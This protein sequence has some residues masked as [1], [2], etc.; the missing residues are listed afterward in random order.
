MVEELHGNVQ[1]L[2][3]YVRQM[4]RFETLFE[5]YETPESKF[6]HAMDNFQP[7]LLNHSNDGGDWREHGVRRSQ[8]MGRQNGTRPGSEELWQ[9]TK[10]LIDAH[11]A[12]GDIKDE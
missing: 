8:V 4:E 11:V 2:R 9:Y 12:K 6:A 10:E 7:L 1:D 3:S 5:A